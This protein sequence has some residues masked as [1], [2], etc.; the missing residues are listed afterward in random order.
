MKP[1]HSRRHLLGAAVALSLLMSAS[2]ALAQLPGE[3]GDAPEGVMAYPSLGVIG[4]FPT[5]SA[6]PVGFIV[7]ANLV[8]LAFFGPT[9][10]PENDGNAGQCPPLFYEQDECYGPIDGDAGLMGPT[11]F[12]IALGVEQPCSPG[13]IIPLGSACQLLPWGPA[14]DFFVTNL[15][16]TDVVINVLFDWNQDGVWSGTTSC[17][18]GN[19][20]DEQQV[21]NLLCRDGYAGMVSGLSPPNIKIGPNAG[22]VWM[23]ISIGEQINFPPSNWHG[24]GMF[25]IG[26]TEDY[27]L[28]VGPQSGELGDA[29]DGALAYP[30]T[31]V[32]GMFPTCLSGAN[33]YILHTGNQGAW[34]GPA[35]DIESDGNAG[36][37]GFP[38]YDNDECSTGDGDAG[39]AIAGS[40]TIDVN[41]NV[42]PCGATRV[43]ALGESCQNAVWGRDIDIHVA[44]GTAQARHVSVLMDW[45]G[46]GRWG[47]DVTCPAGAGSER[48][49]LNLAVP[50][51]FSGDLSQLSPPD[52]TI[53][54]GEGY[55][56]ARCSITDQPV[57]ADWDG[58]GTFADGETED[59]L[60]RVDAAQ[61]DV[62]DE[63]APG[64][65][66]LRIVSTEPNPF[67]ALTRIAYDLPSAGVVRIAVYDASGRCLRTLVDAIRG[68]G[69]HTVEWNG[70]TD[71]GT[72]LGTGTYVLRVQSGDK[73]R[74]S[75]ITLVR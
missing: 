22:Y 56:W 53:F 52:F 10:D 59:Y 8:P 30:S 67:S 44:N 37:C 48:V 72:A 27:L 61:T 17:A 11:A 39:L 3:W 5:C 16:G 24:E 49:L 25:D 55:V 68:P 47:E 12:T 23:R 66:Q 26:E 9:M 20:I 19:P 60:L 57:P 42:V 65:A 2:T 50:G 33:G 71:D 28:Y 70:R 41:N 34:F 46:N 13:A 32:Q 45:D 43:R 51:G 1:A 63:P 4:G 74:S 14:F 29:P 7:H 58:Q 73:V 38:V 40:F 21:V 15:S 64:H 18:A 6:G 35:M 75:K 54:S 31:G 69:P 62:G 36:L